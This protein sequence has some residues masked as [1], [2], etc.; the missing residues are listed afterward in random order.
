MALGVLCD[1]VSD[2]QLRGG[3]RSCA[4]VVFGGLRVPRVGPISEKSDYSCLLGRTTDTGTTEGMR[5]LA[6][7]ATGGWLFSH[8]AGAVLSD[9]VMSRLQQTDRPCCGNAESEGQ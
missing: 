4:G 9:V 6:A 1:R 7:S 2:G 5:R 3:R 8:R